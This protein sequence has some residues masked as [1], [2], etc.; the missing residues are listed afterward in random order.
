M[1]SE[2][3][4]IWLTSGALICSSLDEIYYRIDH[5]LIFQNNNSSKKMNPWLVTCK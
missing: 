1:S 3:E 2:P 4:I 5:S